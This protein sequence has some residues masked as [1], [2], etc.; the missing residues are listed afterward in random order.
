KPGANQLPDYHEVAWQRSNVEVDLHLAL[1]PIVRCDIDYAELWRG[2]RPL[3]VGET[4][5]LTLGAVDSIIFHALHMAV[6]H[7]D[8]PAL[9]L[10]DL[11]RLLSAVPDVEAVHARS[12][13]W[14]ARRPLETALALLDAFLP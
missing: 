7:F 9:Y 10:F 11:R 8:V 5:A 14:R 13:A 3:R 6:D 4:D 2:A 1:V 12:G